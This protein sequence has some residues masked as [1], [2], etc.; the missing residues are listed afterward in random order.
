MKCVP[1]EPILP[2][3]PN[4]GSVKRRNEKKR[5]KQHR[6][7]I[8][9]CLHPKIVLELIHLVLEFL[10]LIGSLGC[11]LYDRNVDYESL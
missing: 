7:F 4:Q 5:I 6:A 2:N 1:G 3:Q 11:F 8:M 9:V 10:E